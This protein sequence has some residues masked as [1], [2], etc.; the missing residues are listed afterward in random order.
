M[1]R[2]AGRHNTLDWMKREHLDSRESV[3]LFALGSERP[4]IE[5]YHKI[6]F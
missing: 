3:S 2:P 4:I 6:A 1:R 5:I